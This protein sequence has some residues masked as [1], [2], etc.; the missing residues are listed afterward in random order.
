MVVSGLESYKIAMPV[1][2]ARLSVRTMKR[3]VPAA[4]PGLMFLSGGQSELQATENLN[5]M[6]AIGPHPWQLSFSFGRALQQSAL[7]AWGGESQNVA[8]AQN[9]LLHR[10]G[11]NHLARSGRHTMGEENRQ[12]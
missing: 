7:K 4:V 5:A 9:V 11:M 2:V 3:C 8:A 12:A 6:N 1:E 10:A